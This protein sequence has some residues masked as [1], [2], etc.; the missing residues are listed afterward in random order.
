MSLDRIDSHG[1]FVG[2]PREPELSLGNAVPLSAPVDRSPAGSGP[3]RDSVRLSQ[4]GVGAAALQASDS[5]QRQL[6]A[7]QGRNP[8]SADASTYDI[9]PQGIPRYDAG[10]RLVG[11]TVI[12]QAPP[13][14]TLVFRGGG[15]KGVGNPSVLAEMRDAGM[16]DGIKHVVGSS[17]GAL[18]ALGL[19]SGLDIPAL[20]ALADKFDGKAMRGAP[21]GGFQSRYP[22]FDTSW[23]PGFQA[24]RVL[25]L[26]DRTT[27]EQ[28]SGYLGA[29]WAGDAFQTRL[30]RLRLAE[31]DG[32]VDR[33]AQL[34]HQ[35][36]GADRSGRM[37][38]FNDLRLLH[39]LEPDRF[40]NLTLTGWDATRG[41]TLYFDA[42]TTPDVPVAVAGR[43]SMGFPVYF[44]SV[45]LDPGDGHG[46]RT[47]TDGGVGS[48]MPVEVVT[49]GLQGKRL[50]HA[51]ARTAVLTFDE[52]GEAYR[53]LHQTPQPPSFGL[54]WVK[55]KLAGWVA[56]NPDYG[57]SAYQD[58]LK[59]H[60]AG[61]N[62]FVVFHGDIGTLDLGASST[63][64][65][66]AQAQ[67][68]LKMREQIA[69]RRGQAYAEEFSSARECFM[70]LNDREKRAI[71][72]GPVPEP[73]A[74][75]KGRDDA[76]YQFERT[77]FEL[78]Q[79]EAQQRKP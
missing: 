55:D 30:E 60:E 53:I 68:A 28:V 11:F 69:L 36:E 19:A 64:R 56:R 76:G 29:H 75:P 72:E 27:A 39:R 24:G 15:A 7:L 77:L 21:D 59:V 65:G 48:N 6:Q 46:L 17:V 41:R 1:V 12:R 62:A 35:D 9:R 52:G 5:M 8:R 54:E 79:H 42:Q 3:R 33:L 26:L 22:M 74:Y 66:L 50:E 58:R 78:A 73:G 2:L 25:E 63:R 10:N 23:R 16:L 61:P 43:I 67:A 45:D 40:K 18:T 32:A 47:F 70:H 38:T 49:N 20:Q 34:R 14:E 44:K 4:E 13:L 57:W 31:G 51:K 71:L 37:I